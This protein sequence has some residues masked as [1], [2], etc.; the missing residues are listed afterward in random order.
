MALLARDLGHL[1]NAAIPRAL[2]LE[3][4]FGVEGAGTRLALVVPDSVAERVTAYVAAGR[5]AL[6][7]APIGGDG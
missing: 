3:H 5:V 2:Q 1:P 7:Q 6:V 4:L